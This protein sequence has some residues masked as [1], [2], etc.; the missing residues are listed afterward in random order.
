MGSNIGKKIGDYL[1]KYIV[2]NPH[3]CWEVFLETRT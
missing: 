2:H 3:Q 1:T